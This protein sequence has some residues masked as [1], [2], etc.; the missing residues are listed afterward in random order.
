MSKCKRCKEE[1]PKGA[2]YCCW[3]GVR[4]K[5]ERQE[6]RIPE[7][8]KLPSGQY[9]IYLRKEHQSITAPTMAE[10]RAKARAF[11]LGYIESEK[12]EN[13]STRKCMERYL[14][15]KANTISPATVRNINSLLRS[16]RLKV[17]DKPIKN[18]NWQRAVSDAIGDGLSPS[19]VKSYYRV[20]KMTASYCGVTMP[21]VK[22]GNHRPQER[23]WL[24]AE[25][26]PL[27]LQ[28]IKGHPYELL[29]ILGLHGLRAGETMAILP[30][31][32][33]GGKI[34]V[35]KAAVSDGSKEL[36]K[37]PKTKSSIRDVPVMI[38]RLTELLPGFHERILTVE[39]ER[40]L[41]V[42]LD[43]LT[44]ANNLPPISFHSL[45]HTFCS[46]CYSLQIPE[47]VCTKLGGW[48]SS[49]TP[50]KIYRHISESDV[51]AGT[52][53]LTAFYSSAKPSAN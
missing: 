50:R 36:I 14:A 41:G 7:P 46:L 39:N 31:D 4:Q 19:S 12:P 45:R 6:I 30:A 48:A 16:D 22:F 25:Q 27:F 40:M 3:C 34:S 32:I 29:Y 24:T 26:I 2:L 10:C 42:E 38:P 17:N 13:I 20:M 28:A 8:T 53:K 49:D 23:Q 33:Q 11:R 43:K 5:A 44:E 47:A 35:T 51:T 21:T 1:L 18:V 37:P 52:E 15:D 9:N